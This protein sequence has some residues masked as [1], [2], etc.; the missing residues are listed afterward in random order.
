M[1]D[2]D[3]RAPLPPSD[4]E[5]ISPTEPRITTFTSLKIRNFLWF[6]LAVITGFAGLQMN[7]VARSWLVWELTGSAFKLGMVAFAFGLPVLLFS[8]IGGAI[9]DRVRKRNLLVITQFGNAFVTLIIAVLITTG[10]IQFWHLV[11][12]GAATGFLFVF[13]GPA[14]MAIIPELVPTRQLLNAI[15]LNSSGMNMTRV[16]APTIA[17]ALLLIIGTAGV[18]YIVVALY[19][20]AAG[21]LWMMSLPRRVVEPEAALP[22]ATAIG[23]S[24]WGGL[25]RA[26]G[27]DLVEGLSYLRHSPLT[28]SLLTM[29][30]VPLVFGL[31]YLN[32]LPVFAD[33]V[34]GVGEFGFGTLI[35]MAGVGSLIASLSLASLGDFRRKGALLFVLALAFGLSLVMFGLSHSYA[36]SMVVLAAVGA[37][38]T[39]YMTLNN[40]LIQSNVPKW[41]LGRVMSIFM[42]TFA[43]M[44]LGT[45]PIGALADTIGVSTAVTAGA[46]I[47]VI[48]V[49]VMAVVQPRLRRLE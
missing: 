19:I 44:P 22:K 5:T 30:F 33:E 41:V 47:V 9:A 26:I 11:A 29:A 25:A 24:R 31:P 7:I 35:A 14:R 32:L 36:L 12:A 6:W 39:G 17:G 16:V 15:S 4:Q 46:G 20:A 13:D 28:I 45:L 21:A 38:G 18:F 42:I 48:F 37:G 10:Q 23:G 43:L 1:D 40:T 2:F 8:L 49:L 3:R 27:A 34:L